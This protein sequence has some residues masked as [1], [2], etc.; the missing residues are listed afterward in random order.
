[1]ITGSDQR[2]PGGA[3][4]VYAFVRSS[5]RVRWKHPAGRGVMTDV[6]RDGDD[7]YAVTLGDELICLDLDDGRLKWTMRGGAG[8]D[9]SRPAMN[10]F[11]TPA[12]AR[13][14]V[15]FGGSDGSVQAV[16]ARDGRT[17]W[18]R[19]VGGRVATPLCLVDGELYLGLADGRVLRLD[20]KT[21]GVRAE[22]KVGGMAFGS[23]LPVRRSLVLFGLEGPDP[24][25]M[26]VLIRCVDR[27]LGAVRWT[28][29]TPGG[30]TSSRPY[31]WRGAVLAGNREGDLV[32]LRP[33]DGSPLWTGRLEGVVR[34]I[35]SDGDRLYVGTLKGR[36]Y[37]YEP[38]P[39]HGLRAADR[40]RGSPTT[41]QPGRRRARRTQGT[42]S[43]PLDRSGPE[44]ERIDR[45]R[46][47]TAPPGHHEHLDRPRPRSEGLGGPA[48]DRPGARGGGALQDLGG[49][50]VRAEAT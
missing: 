31:L 9:E 5:G 22:I 46:G 21:G 48:E 28:R 24:P 30:W 39:I 12:V 36:L 10:I 27:A 47:R 17:V 32:A 2:A 35:G 49:G 44:P 26:V 4:Y 6:V 50:E 43:L 16:E 13:G 25:S 41:V 3:G 29:E 42:R 34:G 11:T 40:R 45:C 18:K 33:G 1:V 37:A 19:E 14:R 8:P 23:A 20:P 15:Y 7:L 38:P